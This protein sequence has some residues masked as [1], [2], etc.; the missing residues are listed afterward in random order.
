MVFLDSLSS[1]LIVVEKCAKLFDHHAVSRVPSAKTRCGGR[2]IQLPRVSHVFRTVTPYRWRRRIATLLVAGV[3]GGRGG[4]TALSEIVHPYSYR[5]F[6][7]VPHCVFGGRC[8]V[9][10]SA[11][12]QTEE[13]GAL[14]PHRLDVAPSLFGA[15]LPGS[16][17]DKKRIQ[18]KR[19]HV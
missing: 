13:K 18:Q 16:G 11:A 3:D 10:S 1:F 5:I 14:S 19:K 7:C 4:G 9:S 6:C 17:L 12:P 8:S 2:K 15:I